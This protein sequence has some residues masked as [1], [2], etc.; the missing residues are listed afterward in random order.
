MFDTPD[1]FPLCLAPFVAAFVGVLIYF[2]GSVTDTVIEAKTG[3]RRAGLS[4]FFRSLIIVV[5]PIACVASA[6]LEI[7][8]RSP[9]PWFTPGTSDIIGEWELTA[10]NARLLKDLHDVTVQSHELVFNEDGTFNLD[11]IPTFWGSWDPKQADNSRTISGSGTWRFGQVEGTE[12][13]E[14]VIIAQFQTLNGRSDNALMRFY[15]ENHLP[16]YILTTLDA[17][18]SFRFQRK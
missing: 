13:L 14:R 9:A 5:I 7:G 6:A 8:V 11:N 16:P 4:A 3:K 2:I 17:Y 10:E 1:L 12:R 18:R 15:F